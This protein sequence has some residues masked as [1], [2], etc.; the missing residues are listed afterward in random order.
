MDLVCEELSYLCGKVLKHSTVLA[1]FYSYIIL[2]HAGRLNIKH[3]VLKSSFVTQ[4]KILRDFGT[5]CYNLHEKNFIHNSF[6]F[7]AFYWVKCIF[8]SEL[9]PYHGCTWKHKIDFFFHR[10][11][12]GCIIMSNAS[13]GQLWSLFRF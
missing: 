12:P 7:L 1:P 3:P 13:I 4:C 10:T 11:P 6:K 9:S 5:Y 2:Y 8:F